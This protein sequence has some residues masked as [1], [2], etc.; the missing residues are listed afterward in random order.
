MMYIAWDHNAQG[1]IHNEFGVSWGYWL[2]LGLGWF[3]PVAVPASAVVG[4]TLSL[5]AY[6]RRRGAV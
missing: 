6:V 3:V 4:S 5:V 2:G 1:E